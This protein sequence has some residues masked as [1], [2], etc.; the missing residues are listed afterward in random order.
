M[1]DVLSQDEWRYGV[2][3]I[4]RQDEEAVLRQRLEAATFL[5][6]DDLIAFL[7]KNRYQVSVHKNLLVVSAIRASDDCHTYS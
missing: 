2:T 1:Q 3:I 4:A 7:R 6:V 5:V